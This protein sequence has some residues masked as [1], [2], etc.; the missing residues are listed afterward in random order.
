MTARLFV[1][2]TLVLG[3]VALGELVIPDGRR[4]YGDVAQLVAAAASAAVCLMAARGRTG[5]QRRWRL[6]AAAGL[7]GWALMR[8]WWAVLDIAQP[9]R[10]L[11]SAADAG[12]LVLPAFVFVGLLTAA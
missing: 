4:L 11:V 12:F 3:A 2:L 6:L 8:L 7:G 9:H 5:V 10:D 1:T